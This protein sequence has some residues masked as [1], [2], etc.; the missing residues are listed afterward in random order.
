MRLFPRSAFA[1]TVALIA[2]L[3]LIN[4]LVSYVMVGLYVVKPSMQQVSSVVA[5]Q[6]Q[7]ILALDQ[8]LSE[9]ELDAE[10]QQ[11]LVERYTQ[12]TGIRG[13]NVEDALDQGLANTTTY[14]FLSAQLSDLLQANTEVR[15][16]QGDVYRVWLRTENLPGY[17][18]TLELDSFDEARFSPLL[19]YLVLIGGLS[20]LGGMV[21][22]NWQNRPLKSLEAAAKQIGSGEYPDAL[23]ER[24]STEVIAVTRA[25]NQMS[26]GVK[27]LEQDRA[28]LMAGISHDLRTPLTRIR[29]ATEMM[30]PAE[31]YLAEGIISDID[32]MN[33][34]IDQFID[35]VRSDTSAD[36]EQQNLNYLV[37][38]VVAHVPDSWH[39]KIEVI[40]NDMP[41]VPVREISIKRVLLNLLENAERYGHHK[42]LIETGYDTERRMAWFK[43]C[44]DGPGIPAAEV[45]HLMQP[46]TQGDK[47][48][49]MKGSGLGLAIIK[50]IIERHHGRVLLGQ[51]ERLGGLCVRVELPV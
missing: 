19:F 28:L 36:N 11:R 40:Y 26:Q 44:D 49:A 15:I 35:Y 38:D 6:V 8:W 34:I 4:Q 27:Q 16:S 51:S 21:F 23:A 9:V 3:L 18:L 30:P 43:V 1:R 46:F 47:A 14:N 32:D 29:L 2:V 25:F 41:N 45:E 24:G 17:W 31:D 20:V 37:E 10:H 39:S 48:R 7:G 22:T 12:A 50:R 5:R 13:V 42:V 33:S